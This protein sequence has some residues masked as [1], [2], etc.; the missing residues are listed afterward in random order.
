MSQLPAIFSAARRRLFFRLIANGTFQAAAIIGSMLLVRHAFN[1]LLNPEF[2]DPE[3][4]MFDVSEVWEI[5]LFALGLMGCT[6]FAAWL[7]FTERV[8]AERL[9]Q[10]YIHQVRLTVFDTMSRFSPRALSERSTG[11][12]M[13]RFVSDLSAI[14]RWVSLGLARIVVSLIV[15]IISISV[16]AYL[17]LYLA[18]C[19]VVILCLGLIWNLKMGPHMHKVITETRRRRGHLAA[20][21]NEKI[22]SYIVIQAFNQCRR[23]R[24]R[25]GKQSQRLSEAM[26]DRAGASAGMRIINEGASAL[27]MAAILSLGALEVFRNMTSSGNVVAAM[28]VVGFLS[29]AFRDLGRVHEYL[30]AYKV[31]TKKILEFMDTQQLRGRSAKLPDLEI[32]KGEIEIQRIRVKGSLRNLSGII[33]GGAKLAMIGDNGA[34]K[35]T[36]LQVIARL[37]DPDRGKVLIDG[38]DIRRCNLTSVRDAIGIVSPDLPLLKGSIRYNLLYRKPDASQE[39]IDRVRQLCKIDDLLAQFPDGEDFRVKEGGENLSL[40]QRHKLALAR[41]LLGQPAI[42]I[43]DEI[44]ASLDQEAVK[45]FVDVITSFPG[46]VLMVSRFADRLALAD[47]Y[48]CLAEGKLKAAVKNKGQGTTSPCLG[49]NPWI[50]GEKDSEQEHGLNDSYKRFIKGS[51]T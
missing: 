6:G 1:V 11:S 7:R 46:T 19:S 14:R 51:A 13:L 4:H 50:K 21:I 27:S 47:E 22:R 10:A 23:E 26:V 33:P 39:E 17:D 43:V 48:W 49:L 24:R 9:G 32:S 34:G 36:L 31:S 40:G 30:Q 41:A 45:V 3:V 38:Q 25:F 8:D 16:L 15:T 28:A 29:T 18:L 42:L 12:S 44:D 5:V 20:N 2:D 37:V 35:S